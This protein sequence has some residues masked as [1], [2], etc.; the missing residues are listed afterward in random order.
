[1]SVASGEVG[2]QSAHL[3]AGL[4]AMLGRK[5]AAI[6]VGDEGAFRHAE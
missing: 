2:E 4:E 3:R 5:A 1:L 6:G